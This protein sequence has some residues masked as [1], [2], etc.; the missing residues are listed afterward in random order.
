MQGTSRFSPIWRERA[1]SLRPRLWIGAGSFVVP[2]CPRP[3]ASRRITASLVHSLMD[4]PEDIVGVAARP[5]DRS[6][7]YR[8]LVRGSVCGLPSG[9]A[10]ARRMDLEPLPRKDLALEAHGWPGETPLWY[11][12]LKEAEISQNG[13]RLGDVGGRI[14]AEVLIGLLEGD[15]NSYLNIQ[16]DWCPTLPASREGD[17]TMADL[18]RV[19]GAV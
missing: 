16:A 10:V 17:F 19:A 6:L 3:Q 12:I 8:D 11:Y 4:L 2:G 15:P 1:R 9:E 13:E 5:E 18:L 14:V 7:A